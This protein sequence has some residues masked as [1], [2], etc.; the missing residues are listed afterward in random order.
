MIKN[1]DAL[2]ALWNSSSSGREEYQ[3]WHS[4]EHVLERLTVP[5]ILSVRRYVKMDGVLPDFLTLYWLTN[6]DVLESTDYL[7][8]I[9][10]PSEWSRNMRGG[11]TDVM[12]HGCA[13]VRHFGRG[14]GGH[15]AV[16]LAPFETISRALTNGLDGPG[17]TSVTVA[18]MVSGFP[19]LPF[20]AATQARVADNDGILLVESF[21]AQMLEEHLPNVDRELAAASAPHWTTYRLAFLAGEEDAVAVKTGLRESAYAH[22]S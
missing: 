21:D 20:A 8:L 2:L 7:K 10:N 12:R 3:S 16:K 5:G 19:D 15:V 4:R 6:I 17:V 22:A 9:Q 14:I 18:R 1:S 13:D 11:L